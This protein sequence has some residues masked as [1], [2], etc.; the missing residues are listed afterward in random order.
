MNGPVKDYVCLDLETSGLYP[1]LDKIIEIGAVKV[2]GGVAAEHFQTFV[3]PGRK[4][5][6]HA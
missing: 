1:R 6:G 3:N 4:L 5:S 2:L